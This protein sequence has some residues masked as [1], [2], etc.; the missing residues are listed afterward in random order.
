MSSQQLGFYAGGVLAD[1]EVAPGIDRTM[2]GKLDVY[3]NARD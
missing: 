2:F 3:T 1:L